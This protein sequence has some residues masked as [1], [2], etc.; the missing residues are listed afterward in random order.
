ALGDASPAMLAVLL[1]AV[2]AN[3]VLVGL[4]FWLVTRPFDARPA[5]PVATMLALIAASGLLNNLPLRPGLVGRSLYLKR[6]HALPHRQ[7]VLVLLMVMALGGLVLG[8]VGLVIV[9]TPVAHHVKAIL[10]AIAALLA[11]TPI[12]GPAM[13]LVAR[14]P[15]GGAWLWIPVRI[16]DM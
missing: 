7:S 13:R 10:L 6:Y 16:V 3:L 14:R 11:L 9:L 15:L 1:A 8:G 5:V 12:T 4:L 2:V